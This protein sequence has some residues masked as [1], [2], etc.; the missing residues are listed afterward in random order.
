VILRRDHFTIETQSVDACLM[1]TQ[2][3]AVTASGQPIFERAAGRFEVLRA[4][5]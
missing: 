5:R 4:S 1:Q 3:I 2:R